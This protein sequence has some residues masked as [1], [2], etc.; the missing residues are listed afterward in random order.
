[1]QYKLTHTTIQVLLQSCTKTLQAPT[2]N[3]FCWVHICN[4]VLIASSNHHGLNWQTSFHGLQSSGPS[5]VSLVF[6]EVF[7]SRACHFL[8]FNFLVIVIVLGQNWWA[9]E[10]TFSSGLIYLVIFLCQAPPP[11]NTIHNIKQYILLTKM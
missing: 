7:T 5:G 4:Q 2:L 11:P 9:V 3:L 1:M 8:G 10:P 6:Q